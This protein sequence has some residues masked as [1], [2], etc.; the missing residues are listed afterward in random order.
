[1]WEILNLDEQAAKQLAAEIKKLVEHVK[2]KPP[3]GRQKKYL[4]RYALVLRTG[5][6]LFLP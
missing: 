1:M 2:A 5:D 4:V 6:D 3:H